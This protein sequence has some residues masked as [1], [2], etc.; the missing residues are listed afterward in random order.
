MCGQK[1]HPRVAEAERLLIDRACKDGGWDYGNHTALGAT[2]VAY[3]PTSALAAL[4]LQDVAAAGEVVDRGLAFMDREIQSRQSALSLALTILCFNVFGK[5]TT[6]L[7]QALCHRQEP[8]GS[9]RQQV[10]VTALAMLALEATGGENVF[11]L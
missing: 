6:D 1:N 9:W 11:K 8:D 5:V 3:V 7:A 2:L 4:A 10:H